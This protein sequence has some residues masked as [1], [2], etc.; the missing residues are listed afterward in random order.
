LSVGVIPKILKIEFVLLCFY[1]LWQQIKQGWVSEI[2]S[3]LFE[4]SEVQKN[5]VQILEMAKLQLK[6]VM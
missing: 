2:F 1:F 4:Q 3:E 6:F 5:L